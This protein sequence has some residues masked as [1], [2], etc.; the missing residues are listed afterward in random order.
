MTKKCSLC[1]IEKDLTNFYPDKRGKLGRYARCNP[2]F[3]SSKKPWY[4]ANKDTIKLKQRIFARGYVKSSEQKK[5]DMQ[6]ASAKNS[7]RRNTDTNYAARRRFVGLL[8]SLVRKAKSSYLE[9]YL[10]CSVVEFRAHLESK[11][12]PGMTWENYG[13]TGWHI[14]HIVSLSGFDLTKE[15]NVKIALHFTNTQPL[16]GTEN[17]S[18]GVRSEPYDRCEVLVSEESTTIG[19]FFRSL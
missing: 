7:Q 13:R 2:C 17:R 1:L 16:W 11:F 14:D 8:S 19:G 9:E 5:K 10:G 3:N 15:A 4:E 18:K 6:R 12:K